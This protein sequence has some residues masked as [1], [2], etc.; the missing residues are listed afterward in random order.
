MIGALSRVWFHLRVR[1]HLCRLQFARQY[2]GVAVQELQD[3]LAIGPRRLAYWMSEM[4]EIEDHI[5]AARALLGLPPHDFNQEN[6]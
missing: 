5:N 1:A 3:D 6:E 4:R 2:I